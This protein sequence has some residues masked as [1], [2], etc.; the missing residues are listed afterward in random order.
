VTAATGWRAA[1]RAR[2]LLGNPGKKLLDAHSRIGFGRGAGSDV[3][4]SG[5]FCLAGINLR[6]AMTRPV[7]R[8][9]LP[10][11]ARP[12]CPFGFTGS[13][14]QDPRQ[15]LTTP[16]AKAQFHR[17]TIGRVTLGSRLNYGGPADEH[18]IQSKAMNA[19]RHGVI[20][21]SGDRIRFMLDD[22]GRYLI[23]RRGTIIMHRRGGRWLLPIGL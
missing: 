9:H 14:Q 7:L 23:K 13:V 10:T 17:R 11:Q 4:H 19:G 21:R 8:D 6:Q 20:Y 22:C 2:C 5:A 16:S 15:A 12:D 18:V 1:H 3:S